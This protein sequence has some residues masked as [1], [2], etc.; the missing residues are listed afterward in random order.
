MSTSPPPIPI[1]PSTP[2]EILPAAPP[3]SNLITTDSS[4]SIQQI[5]HLVSPLKRSAPAANALPSNNDFRSKKH[6]DYP[7]RDLTPITTAREN[8]EYAWNVRVIICSSVTDQV[9]KQ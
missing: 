5:L 3:P 6:H 9:L 1:L 2:I 8:R 7:P 4:Q